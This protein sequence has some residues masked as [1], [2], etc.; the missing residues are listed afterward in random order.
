MYVHVY[1]YM[2]I[3]MC[4]SCT[5]SRFSD[6][7]LCNTPQHIL[8]YTVRYC[9]N[10]QHTEIT[11]CNNAL[12]HTAT[13]CNTLQHTA[14]QCNTLPR[15]AILHNT[16]KCALAE[17]FHLRTHTRTTPWT[18][19]FLYGMQYVAV[20]PERSASRGAHSAHI[21]VLSVLQCVAVSCSVSECVA[22]RFGSFSCVAVYCSVHPGRIAE[23][24]SHGARYLCVAVCCSVLQC[25]SEP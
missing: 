21:Y 9:N 11:R 4:K 23:S 2:Y 6:L 1:I 25:A 17:F 24:D 20:C 14:T 10:Q 8:H 3:Y 12:Q 19:T 15:T 22:V 18:Y 5:G 13:H 7:Y 16:Y